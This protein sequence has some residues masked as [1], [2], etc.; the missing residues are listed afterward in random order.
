MTIERSLASA[1]MRDVRERVRAVVD[2][3]EGGDPVLI[4]QHGQP[5]AVLIRHAEAERWAT[6]ERS[7][8]ALHAVGVYPELVRDTAELASWIDSKSTVDPGAIDRLATTPREITAPLRTVNITDL[9][10][11]LAERLDEVKAGRSLT[12]VAGG[13][14]AATL[15]SP[16]EFDRLRSLARVVAWFRAAGL[17]LATDDE[18]VIATFVAA[19]RARSAEDAREAS[20]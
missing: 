12:I 19:R 13:R 16:R 9:R 3:V 8:S 20:G 15:I 14:L 2:S 10:E 4:L 1:G 7:L 17:D 11:H 5:A 6:I 18:A